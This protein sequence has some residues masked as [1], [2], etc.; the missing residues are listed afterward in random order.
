MQPIARRHLIAAAAAAALPR[1]ARAAT[2]LRVGD[3]KGGYK[4]LMEASGVLR[5]IE[6]RIEWVPFVAAA[7]LLE[8]LNAG[9]IDCG[10]VGDAP[11]AFARAAGLRAKVIVATRSSGSSTAMLVPAGSTARSFSDLKGRTIGTGRGSVG[12]FLVVAAREQAGLSPKDVNLAFL[13]PA[14]AKAAFVGGSI[15][16]WSTWSQYV[17]LAVVQNGARVLL[18]GQGL[19]S[20][21][22]YF[23]A[24]ERAIGEKR[25]VLETFAQRL[26][27]ALRWGLEHVDAYAEAWAKKISVPYAVSR[28]TLLARGFSPVP[29]DAGVIAD[30]QHTIDVYVKEGVLPASY[31]ARPAFDPSFNG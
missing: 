27:T 18:D 15:A 19:M 9:A 11:F 4:S 5:D 23:V 12:H 3:Q 21:L 1:G 7:P 13:A 26:R 16:A 29:V 25:D 14:D 20:G 8:A 31:D 10:G 30:Q 22:S 24:A 17:W 6:H 2:V 28:Q